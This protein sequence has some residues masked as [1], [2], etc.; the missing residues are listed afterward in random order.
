M[1]A[2]VFLDRDGTLMEDAGYVREAKDVVVYQGVRES[3]A[4]L[5]AA[6]YWL[7]VVTNQSGI[8]RGYYGESE[9][10]AVHDEFVRQLGGGLIDAAYFCPDH[11]ESATDRRKPGPGMLL[12]AAR[13]HGLDLANSFMVGD[14]TGDLEAGRRAGVAASILV[15]TGIGEA[16]VAKAGADFVADDFPSASAWIL[17]RGRKCG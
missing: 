16:E 2:A 3:L 8:G 11:P 5:K 12:E 1:N 15:R 17:Q 9:Y 7:V 4:A 10:H 13:E 6:G 14:R